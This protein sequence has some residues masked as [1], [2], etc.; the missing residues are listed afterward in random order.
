M[1]I[2]R[3]GK[4]S[5]STILADT[6]RKNQSQSKDKSASHRRNVIDRGK[7]C[8]FGKLKKGKGPHLGEGTK[9]HEMKQ[10]T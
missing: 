6:S 8:V 2:D 10:E 9:W 3:P 5:I 4:A 7:M 1:A